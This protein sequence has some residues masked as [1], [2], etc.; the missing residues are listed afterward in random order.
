[1]LYRRAKAFG[2]DIAFRVIDHIGHYEFAVPGSAAWPHVL[3][4]LRELAVWR[5]DVIPS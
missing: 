4:A 1:V 3:A 5:R 2:D